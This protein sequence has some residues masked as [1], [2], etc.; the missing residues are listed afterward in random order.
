MQSPDCPVLVFHEGSSKALPA[1]AAELFT[2]SHTGRMKREFMGML[3]GRERNPS[4]QHLIKTFLFQLRTPVKLTA[5]A[6][7]AVDVVNIPFTYR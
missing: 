1:S 4:S 6:A 7:K 5:C 2:L 3:V